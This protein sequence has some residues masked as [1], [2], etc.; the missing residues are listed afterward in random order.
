MLKETH[1][2]QWL[3][4]RESDGLLW[5]GLLYH[6]VRLVSCQENEAMIDIHDTPLSD[7][8]FH[9]QTCLTWHACFRDSN[10]ST[11]HAK[12]TWIAVSLQFIR[13]E[14]PQGV[15]SSSF[16]MY[17][18]HVFQETVIETLPSCSIALYCRRRQEERGLSYA[19]LPL[20]LFAQEFL[21]QIKHEKWSI[22][23]WF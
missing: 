11:R 5:H 1:S 17:I 18:K 13:V 23:R 9:M 4:R 21:R 14:K 8:K 19:S 16:Q 15:S 3:E 6:K 2:I 22:E 10:A 7:Q 12:S 20:I